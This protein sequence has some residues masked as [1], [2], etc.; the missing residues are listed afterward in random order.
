VASYCVLA[1]SLGGFI[2]CL[3]N[4]YLSDRIGRRA[5]FRLYGIGFVIMAAVYLFGPWGAD[6]YLLVPIG[7]VYGGFQFGLYASFGPFFT[8][9]FPTELRGSGQSFA[10][11]SGR[12]AGALYIMGVPL[13]AQQLALSAAMAVFA[14]GAILVAIFATFLLPETAGRA[15]RSM[16][17][18]P[19]DAKSDAVPAAGVPL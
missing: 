18:L 13:L 2:G 10:Y 19:D 14:I 9:L 12:A 5:V 11:N 15:L 4:A 17:D 16:H 3:V 6:L 1:N 8:E 7:L